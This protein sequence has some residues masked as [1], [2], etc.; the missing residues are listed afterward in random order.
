MVCLLAGRQLSGSKEY[1]NRETYLSQRCR[2]LA[3]IWFQMRKNCAHKTLGELLCWRGITVGAAHR[4]D[5][6]HESA[7]GSIHS[8]GVVNQVQLARVLA[9]HH[10]PPALVPI[11]HELPLQAL[12]DEVTVH[13]D[14][15]AAAVNVGDAQPPL[16]YR[17]PS[18]A[19]QAVQR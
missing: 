6:A 1:S 7:V 3:E 9:C 5:D 8:H 10:A 16:G 14:V 13:D 4:S 11:Q 18:G 12:L 17:F 15:A 19:G 2:L